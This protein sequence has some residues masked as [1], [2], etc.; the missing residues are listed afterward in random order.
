MPSAFRRARREALH[1]LVAWGICMIWTIG[2]CAFFAYG[3]GDISLLWGM[4]QW[5]VFGIALPWVIA[6]LY[7]LWFALF[8]MKAEDL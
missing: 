6:T 8:Y 7:S 2:Y 4:P 1:I 5:V 3:S